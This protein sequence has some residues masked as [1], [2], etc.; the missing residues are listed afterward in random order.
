MFRPEKR[1]PSEW[2]DEFTSDDRP[3]TLLGFIAG[4]VARACGAAIE[5][6]QAARHGEAVLQRMETYL[7][8]RDR[9]YGLSAAEADALLAREDLERERL[10]I[11]EAKRL[12]AGELS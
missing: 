12:G 4:A 2:R 10:A 8:R 7:Q 11:E 6:A 9:M 1:R 5:A 3:V